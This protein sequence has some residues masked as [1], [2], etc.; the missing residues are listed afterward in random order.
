MALVL[1]NSVIIA[2][3]V[4]AQATD[5][6]RRC[7]QRARRETAVVPA[8]WESEFVNVLLALVK[9][10]S[11][12]RHQAVTALHHAGRL[13]LTID[14]E[15]VASRRLFDLAEAHGISAYDAVYLELATRRGLPLATRDESLARCCANQPHASI[16][17]P[18]CCFISPT[19]RVS[20]R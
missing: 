10:K 5:Y 12:P 20:F 8:L 3:F 13:P 19:Q 11:L 6:T 4:P 2:W 7:N 15:P 18:I 14:R 1:D 17:A 9:L 16:C